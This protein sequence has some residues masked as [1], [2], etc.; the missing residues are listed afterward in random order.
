MNE[1]QKSDTC[2]RLAKIEGQLRGVSKMIAEERNCIDVLV[3]TRT[4]VSGTRK[5]ENLIMEQHL[6]T[7]VAKS[8][9]SV[10]TDEKETKVREIM[11]MISRFRCSL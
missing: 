3:R 8:M 1:A 2:R 4:I 11:D 5:V 7:C 10:S 9:R 6:H